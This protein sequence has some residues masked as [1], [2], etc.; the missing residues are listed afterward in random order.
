MDAKELAQQLN[1]SKYP[2]DI[3]KALA[4]LAK[5]NGLVIVYGA[6]DDLMEF[7]GA[8]RDEVGAYEGTTVK[9][10]AKGLLP[11]FEDINKDDKDALRKYF[12]TESIGHSTIEA[13]WCK[14]DGYS[15][16]YK[17]AIP[18]ATFDVLEDG[19]KYCRGIVFKLSEAGA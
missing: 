9:I 8:F 10:S 17:T 18:H 12:A 16:T 13:L 6:S 3:P 1:G 14:E 4:Q 15:F 11:N 2:C 7:D 19:D 5:D